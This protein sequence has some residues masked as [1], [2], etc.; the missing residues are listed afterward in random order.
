MTAYVCRYCR[1][2]TDPAALACPQCGTP[3]AAAAVTRSGW[4]RQPALRDLAR[5]QFSRSSCQIA[6]STV[7]VAE[8]IL[9]P[10][11]EVYFAP[12]SFL[13]AGAG[14]DLAIWPA[15]PTR[16]RATDDEP[17]I[18]M[19][20]RGP[21]WIGLSDNRAGQIVAL[22]LRDGRRIW[23]RED[24]FLA[25]TGNVNRG[26][27]QLALSYESGVD[28]ATHH[29][30]GDVAD[31]FSTTG[32]PGLL[33]LHSPGSTYIRDLDADEQVLVHP[34]ALLYKDLSVSTELCLEYPDAG[35]SILGLS[36]G[37]HC[38]WVGLHGPGR[39]AVQSCA[40]EISSADRVTRHFGIDLRW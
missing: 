13:C 14:V 2:T 32:D 19:E 11:D 30:L 6:G 20:A 38:T 10:N 24:R 29:L 35:G 36:F 31:I 9:G 23:V 22:P 4:V 17:L 26:W 27:H 37:Y 8:F 12:R 18:T 3:V 40:D 25:A 34:G 15:Y 5:L 7:P 33:L 1:Q 39:V 16:R 21:G 28:G